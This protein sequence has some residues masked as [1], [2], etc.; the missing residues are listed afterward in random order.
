[1]KKL[2][3]ITFNL[4]V[5]TKKKLSTIETDH[6]NFMMKSF[7]CIIINKIINITH[8]KAIYLLTDNS[9]RQLFIIS[10]SLMLFYRCHYAAVLALTMQPIW[11]EALSNFFNTTKLILLDSL[12][13]E[14]TA[15]IMY[16][17]INIKLYILETEDLKLVSS[18]YEAN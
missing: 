17:C 10:A 16:V 9:Q 15:G 7:F 5:F 2:A 4:T 14:V 1:M 13:T 8:D 6:M 12:L 11:S 18:S 3:I